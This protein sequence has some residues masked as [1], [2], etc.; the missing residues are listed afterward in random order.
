MDLEL[1][2]RCALVT[3]SSSGIGA[4][5]AAALAAEGA[6][7]V[8]HGRDAERSA[9]V[10]AGIRERGGEARAVLGDI[11]T[12]AGAAEVAA[13][14]L[15][16]GRIDILVN[17]TGGVVDPGAGWVNST[18]AFWAEQYEL[19]TLS[20]VRMVGHVAPGM[21]EAG[22][23]RIIQIGSVAAVTPLADQV[24]AYC[25]AKAALLAIG[26]S[27]AKTLAG[28]GITVNTVS[29]GYV[30]TP[31]LESYARSRPG[32]E[33]RG[34]AKI[35]AEMASALGVLA[36]RL[37]QPADI[38]ALTAFLASPRADWITGSNIRIDG[39]MCGFVD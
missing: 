9:R 37:G 34:W 29:P 17:T 31:L 16:L 25:A 14:A 12:D 8:V 10:A 35:E 23:G 39:G 7:V 15:R 36:G 21:K 6:G 33:T 18:T 27:L 11:T 28:T 4:G 22:W 5:I 26:V 30:V 24:P 38:A 19:N 32:N 1:A 2:G 13:A 3:G 20:S